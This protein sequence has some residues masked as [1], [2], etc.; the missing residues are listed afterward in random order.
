M[1]IAITF[2]T[3]SSCILHLIGL[4]ALQLVPGQCCGSRK[5][6]FRLSNPDPATKS[7]KMNVI[8][9]KKAGSDTANNPTILATCR[10]KFEL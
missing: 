8:Y 3:E 10:Y 1:H 6:N 2:W 5:I 7:S 9:V 4:V